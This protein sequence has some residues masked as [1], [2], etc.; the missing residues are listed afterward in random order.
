[1]PDTHPGV[2]Q[3]ANVKSLTVMGEVAFMGPQEL[4]KEIEGSVKDLNNFVFRSYIELGG[5]IGW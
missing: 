2:A 5:F 4:V 3:F 1:M